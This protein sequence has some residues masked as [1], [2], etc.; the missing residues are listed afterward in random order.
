[1]EDFSHLIKRKNE[2]DEGKG[3]LA[4]DTKPEEAKALLDKMKEISELIKNVSLPYHLLL[5][6]GVFTP[7]RTPSL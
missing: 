3:L 6:E 4:D 7:F 1:M 5:N 2:S